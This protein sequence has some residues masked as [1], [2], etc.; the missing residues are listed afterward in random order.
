MNAKVLLEAPLI[1]SVHSKFCCHH[2]THDKAA[3]WQRNDVLVVII[4]RGC[5]QESTP[6]SYFAT[7]LRE[8]DPKAP[9]EVH[10]DPFV[11]ALVLY[12]RTPSPDVLIIHLFLYTAAHSALYTLKTRES[13]A[14]VKVPIYSSRHSFTLAK[15][16]AE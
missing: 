2:I 5:C 11:F 10:T 13:I 8:Y 7:I 12:M 6:S 1:Q 15:C 9:T 4:A 3:R 16:R 14:G